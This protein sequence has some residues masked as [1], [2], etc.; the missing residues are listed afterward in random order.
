M[1]T[2][3]RIAQPCRYSFRWLPGKPSTVA[4][5]PWSGPAM[6]EK[7]RKKP[8]RLPKGWTEYSVARLDCLSWSYFLPSPLR[9]IR[10]LSS[11]RSTP[12]IVVGITIAI[13]LI[14]LCLGL[15]SHG[16][17]SL[18]MSDWNHAGSSNSKE[19]KDGTQS[20]KLQPPCLAL[21]PPLC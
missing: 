16:L 11:N 4:L 5:P 2:R 13:A 17:L 14:S 3:C 7:I 6:D 19:T 15:C 18:R 20:C 8:V 10:W 12:T 21:V 1:E 9:L